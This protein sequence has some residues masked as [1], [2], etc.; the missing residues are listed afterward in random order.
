MILT[1]MS[2]VAGALPGLVMMLYVAGRGSAG[3]V[4]LSFA[5]AM[6]GGLLGYL[7]AWLGVRY[8]EHAVV[9]EGH[10]ALR[11][12]ARAWRAANG[13]RIELAKIAVFGSLVELAG[14]GWG[15]MTFGW[16]VLI[17]VPIG[18]LASDYASVGQWLAIARVLREEDS[19]RP[20]AFVHRGAFA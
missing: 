16:G 3:L 4:W 9:L 20:P 18:R 5:V 17:G 19:I 11:A 13:R 7:H 15:L 8:A 6:A 12:L 2:L 14:L 1:T 10:G